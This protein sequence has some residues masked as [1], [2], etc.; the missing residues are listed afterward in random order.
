MPISCIVIEPQ[1]LVQQPCPW[2]VAHENPPRWEEDLTLTF[3]SLPTCSVSPLLCPNHGVR[4][5]RPLSWRPPWK[6]PKWW[7]GQIF[8]SVL[9]RE[10]VLVPTYL[11]LPSPPSHEHD[12]V[13]PLDGNR[14]TNT[15]AH[16]FS[17]AQIILNHPISLSEH[18]RRC[19]HQSQHRLAELVAALCLF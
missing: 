5:A 8:L 16:M 11:Q 7:A 4:L 2:V 12:T 10:E 17:K 18:Y 14:S 6:R 9:W 1:L 13:F 15:W 19:L 3:C